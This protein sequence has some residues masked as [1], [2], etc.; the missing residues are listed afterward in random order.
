MRKPGWIP[1]ALLFG[2]APLQAQAHLNSVDIGDFWLGVLHPL[3]TLEDALAI[4]ALGLLAGQCGERNGLKACGVFSLLLAVGALAAINGVAGAWVGWINLASLL[5]L[6]GFVALRWTPPPVLM[7]LG[8]VFGLT[9]G[10]A[11]G[12]EIVDPVK[13]WLFIP[14][15]VTGGFFVT[16]YTMLAVVNLKPWWTQIGVR[17]IGSWIAAIG[18]LIIALDSLPRPGA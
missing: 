13:P 7:G 10:I 6:G 16:F 5:L 1:A 11:N 3:T 18:L 4:L 2:A 9:H 17:V 15:L 8:T 14:G 12:V